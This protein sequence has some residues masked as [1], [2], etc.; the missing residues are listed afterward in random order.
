[1]NVYSNPLII[2]FVILSSSRLISYANTTDATISL[3][4]TIIYFVFLAVLAFLLK[5][6][7]YGK[8]DENERKVQNGKER[9]K[10][11]YFLTALKKD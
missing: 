5:I 9:R 7:G 2:F 11:E 1:M 3:F 6:I 4:T 8:R 10:N